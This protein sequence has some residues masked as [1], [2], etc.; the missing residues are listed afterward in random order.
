MKKRRILW[1]ES[2]DNEQQQSLSPWEEVHADSSG[3]FKVRSKQG[4]RYYS[5]FVCS[6]TGLKVVVPHAKRKHFPLA[7]L[8]FAQRINQ[9]PRVLYTDKGGEN[10]SKH[11]TCLALMKHMTHI[12]VPKGEHHS[13]V[14]AEK[15]IQDLDQLQ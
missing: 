15:A 6:K 4:N 13:I 11:M 5:V 10:C 8:Q 9:H 14:A 12:V 1:P 7:Y 2:L 3:K